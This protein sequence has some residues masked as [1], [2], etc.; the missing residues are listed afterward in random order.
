[1]NSNGIHEAEELYLKVW[2]G[3]IAKISYY[4]YYI[5]PSCPKPNQFFVSQNR[6]L[7]SIQISIVTIY[8]Y[9]PFK[10]LFSFF[11]LFFLLTFEL[12]HRFNSNVPSRLLVRLL[13]RL[14]FI[15]PFNSG[16]L[17]NSL[18]WRWWWQENY[19][20]KIHNQLWNRK[21]K[22]N[23]L[24]NLLDSKCQIC[25]WKGFVPSVWFDWSVGFIFYIVVL[26]FFYV[27][28]FV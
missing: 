18:T 16:I 13:H 25:K 4:T 24:L 3:S 28:L 14:P 5:I 8:F 21:H 23:R 22:S 17:L 11:F 1:M 19:W 15:H 26:V 10:L 7:N 20:K 27:S 2:L 12:N 9:A 6:L